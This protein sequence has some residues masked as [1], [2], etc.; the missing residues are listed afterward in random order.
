[1][2]EFTFLS[3]VLGLDDVDRVCEQ[4]S[5]LHAPGA[6]IGL[7]LADLDTVSPAP[8]AIILATL[9]ELTAL[10]RMD[11]GHDY[12]APRANE[13]A[14]SLNVEALTRVISGDPV[15]KAS[16][17]DRP[18]EPRACTSFAGTAGITPAVTA[19]HAA[20]AQLNR[21]AEQP[22]LAF[23]MMLD[24][25]VGNVC[26]HSGARSGVAAVELYPDS[27][28]LE[29]AVADCGM[30][31]QRSLSQNPDYHEV[32]DLGAIQQALRGGISG[33]VGSGRGLGLFL[34]RLVVGAN[35][36]ILLVRSGTAGVTQAETRKPASG[37]PILRGTLVAVRAR[38]DRPFDYNVVNEL[39]EKPGG[40]PTGP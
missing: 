5:P 37:L 30:G 38:I 15:T 7:D 33:N 31:I 35:D 17:F 40:V 21:L 34:T 4:L 1:V 18:P 36:G 27:Q 8:L 6:S 11:L 22:L 39:L 13:L 26:A 16:R 20:V 25:L 9:R 10:R 23:G 28:E 24:E 19:L 3:G 2:G 14:A 29:F 12:R 32:D